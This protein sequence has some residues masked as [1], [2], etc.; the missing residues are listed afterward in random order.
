MVSVLC[1]CDYRVVLPSCELV[2]TVGN[3][4]S[5]ICCPG[6]VGNNI[7]PYRVVC[8]ECKKFVPVSDVVSCCNFESLVIDSLYSQIIWISL[9]NFEHVAIVST[10][11]CAC[12]SLPCELEVTSCDSLAIR[13]L[14]VTDCVC[15]CD[16]TVSIFNTINKRFSS[17]SNDDKLTVCIL[18]PLCETGEEVSCKSSTINSTVKSWVDCVWL[19]SDTDG[20]R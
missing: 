8:W 5:R 13:P 7:L 12:S 20:N 10:K 9:Y 2:H 17:I 18:I 16:G 1:E 19:G 6:F 3:V 15:V 4:C 14:H 11:R